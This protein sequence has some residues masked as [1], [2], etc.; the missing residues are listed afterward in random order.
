[1]FGDFLLR[2]RDTVSLTARGV[3]RDW[4]PA[5]VAVGYVGHGRSCLGYR[6]HRLLSIFG[7]LTFFLDFPCSVSYSFSP[8]T[9]GRL[10]WSGTQ[11]RMDCVPCKT[12]GLLFFATVCVLCS[13]RPCVDYASYGATVVWSLW[14]LP[15]V[16][17]G[18]IAYC[19]VWARN[20]D[21]TILAD[22]IG[23]GKFRPISLIGCYYKVVAKV[24]AERVE[25][26]VGSVGGEMQNAFI[27]GRFILDG[28][29][30]ANETVEYLK[31]KKEKGLIF[32]VNFKKAYD[33]IN[34]AFLSNMMRRMGF[35]ERW[36]KWI[37]N[38]LK[39]SSMSILVNGS[40]MDEFMLERG[41]RQG[42]SLSL[43]L[44][45]LAAEGL[46]ALVSEAV[47]KGIFKEVLVDDERIEV[48]HLQ[49]ADDTI[50]FGE[51]S[52][53]NA[54][55]LMCSGEI[56][57]MAQWMRCS[58][59]E[60]PFTYLGLPIGQMKRS[61]AWR[62]VIEK[63]KKRLCDWKAKMMSFG[64]EGKRVGWGENRIWV[65]MDGYGNGIGLGSNMKG[66]RG[67]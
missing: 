59:G 60:L 12:V 39:S 9:G 14:A 46:N 13:L 67:S 11:L 20:P 32:K 40:P 50:F 30:I 49:Y 41:V 34:W 66:A 7:T 6:Y 65:T 28:I 4:T 16:G 38:C 61:N 19:M 52:M 51:W 24:I 43:F 26:V 22:P 15:I 62:P 55:S 1:M 54:R 57:E 23:L 29:L 42:D 63:F 64:I 53:E 35:R 47:D 8:V 10:S 37:E 21:D 56:D 48:S 2:K 45:I 36:C 44:F 5:S 27:K 25:K 33:S 31:R 17:L 3:S 58:V 18:L